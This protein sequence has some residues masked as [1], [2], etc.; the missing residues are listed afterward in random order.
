M[1]LNCD[2]SWRDPFKPCPWWLNTLRLMSATLKLQLQ[3]L[4][5]SEW[6]FIRL[7]SWL[8]LTDFGF[9]FFRHQRYRN[10]I[11]RVA[12]K[13]LELKGDKVASVVIV[14]SVTDRYFRI[15]MWAITFHGDVWER[16]AIFYMCYARKV[17]VLLD[18]CCKN[19]CA[20]STVTIPWAVSWFCGDLLIKSKECWELSRIRVEIGKDA[21]Y[22]HWIWLLAVFCHYIRCIMSGSA[23]ECWKHT[24]ENSTSAFGFLLLANSNEVTGYLATP[25]SFFLIPH[26][27]MLKYAVVFINFVPFGF[28]DRQRCC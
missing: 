9:N 19:E 12:E 4:L 7:N 26:E 5:R 17:S 22:I 24:F 8:K 15:F 13:M 18:Q 20:S 10:V 14:Y 28:C 16:T 23:P 3:R 2:Y 21:E 11:S 6:L 27:L 25:N 1:I